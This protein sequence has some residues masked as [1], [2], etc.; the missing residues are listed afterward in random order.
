MKPLTHY[1]LTGID[2]NIITTYSILYKVGC[3]LT[4]KIIKYVMN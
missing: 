2:L 3:L 1:I 4:Y